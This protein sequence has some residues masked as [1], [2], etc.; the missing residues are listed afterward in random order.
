MKRS[1]VVLAL[2][3]VATYRWMERRAR[4]RVAADEDGQ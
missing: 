2:A 1:K 3:L 4:D